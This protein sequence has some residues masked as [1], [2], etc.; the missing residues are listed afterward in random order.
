MLD[1]Q[2]T[3]RIEL[4]RIKA[5]EPLRFTTPAEREALLEDAG[6]NLFGVRAEHVLIDLLTDS[7]TGAMSADQWAGMMVGD[8]SYAGSRSFFRFL[9]VVTELTGMGHVIR[10]HQGRAAER[11]LTS[12]LSQAPALRHFTA[13]FEPVM[14]QPSVAVGTP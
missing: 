4:F 11:I 7:G 8:E 6:Y 14:R 1:D 5:V 13:R 10:I 3:T 9:D 12:E 2:F